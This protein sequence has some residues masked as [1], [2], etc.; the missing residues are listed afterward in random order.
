MTEQ[1]SPLAL[2]VKNAVPFVGLSRSELYRRMHDGRL[3]CF[4]AGRRTL[5]KVA[6]LQRLIDNLP[7]RKAA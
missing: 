5:I 3:P 2:S 4:K 6:D 1:Q 7:L